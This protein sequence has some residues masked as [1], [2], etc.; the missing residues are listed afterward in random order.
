MNI[1]TAK[2]IKL[3][4]YIEGIEIPLLSAHIQEGVMATPSCTVNIGVN[5]YAHFLLPGSL[6]QLFYNIDGRDVLIFEGEL[7]TLHAQKTASS[8]STSL[9]FVG[10]T[11]MLEHA[12]IHQQEFS[13]E[14]YTTKPF[15]MSVS[16]YSPYG[17][18]AKGEPAGFFNPPQSAASAPEPENA[19]PG[20]ATI[21][22]HPETKIKT[23][24][25][26][27]VDTISA[28]QD[29]F[30]KNPIQT[31]IDVIMA[32]ASNLNPYFALQNKNL[33]I[34]ERIYVFENAKALQ[35]LQGQNSIEHFFGAIKA[36][37]KVI[38]IKQLIGIICDYLGYDWV[39]LAAPCFVGGKPKSIIIKPKTDFMLPILTN[40]VYP[41]QYTNFR[42]TRN[43]LK[44]P[45]RLAVTSPPFLFKADTASGKG[46]TG[47]FISVVPSAEIVRTDGVIRHNLT[48][49]EKYK[50]IYPAMEPQPNFLEQ[51]YLE[52]GRNVDSWLARVSGTHQ[53]E[54]APFY[55]VTPTAKM[56]LLASTAARVTGTDYQ[57]DMLRIAERRFFEIRANAKSANFATSYSPYH[58]VGFPGAL[59]DIDIPHTIGTFVSISSTLSADGNATQTIELAAPRQYID[60]D[61]DIGLEEPPSFPEFYSE[62]FLP[63]N[64][65]K[66]YQKLI[67]NPV[68]T[69]NYDH[70]SVF[71][72][73]YNKINS[74]PEL[75]SAENKQGKYEGATNYAHRISLKYATKQYQAT[76]NSN[77]HLYTQYHT[78]R[79]LITEAEYWAFLN[80]ANTTNP[81]DELNA[82]SAPDLT[83]GTAYTHFA[84]QPFVLE[85]MKRVKLM[86]INGVTTNAV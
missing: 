7:A 23:L 20:E 85:R 86:K 59:L 34:S 12:W 75:V 41:N 70:G 19:E 83:V 2:K 15:F 56:D 45:S 67:N 42:F 10:L 32:E 49:E 79:G 26:V 3:K 38:S 4:M 22:L 64:I 31:L 11:N 77:K 1:G 43:Y 51:S 68:A 13:V 33:Y 30:K 5:K 78:K 36:L 74:D 52:V 69:K 54:P 40:T 28:A 76:V 8:K 55:R 16:K 80:L 35:L 17:G 61:V 48:Q 82:R 58:M 63:E 21:L 18:K 14:S 65:G 50:G 62:V 27:V 71:M 47:F 60:E 46:L 53:A 39:E 29:A 72:Y 44:E 73:A 66:E 9:Q 81:E 25:Q 6:M 24:L 37:P 57:V 84:G